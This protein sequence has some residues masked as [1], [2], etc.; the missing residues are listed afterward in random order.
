MRNRRAMQPLNWL[1]NSGLWCPESRKNW[2]R[3]EFTHIS[4]TSFL[5]A[6]SQH[7]PEWLP[8][9]FISSTSRGD[10]GNGDAS[11][12]VQHGAAEQ[13]AAHSICSLYCCSQRWLLE[14]QAKS[15]C[16]SFSGFGIVYIYVWFC[17]RV[18]WTVRIAVV[19]LRG[20]VIWNM[21]N[22]TEFSKWTSVWKVAYLHIFYLRSY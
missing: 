21:S 2:C 9:F 16:L 11:Q 15:C 17:W 14:L 1:E 13:L 18:K 4:F 19:I 22:Y 7:H 8:V 12:S 6:M 5:A 3:V 10:W 20:G